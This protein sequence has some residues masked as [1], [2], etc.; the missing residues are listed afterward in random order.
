MTNPNRFPNGFAL[1]PIHIGAKRSSCF[2]EGVMPTM[3]SRCF[4]SVSQGERTVPTSDEFKFSCLGCGQYLLAND[5]R[6]GRHLESRISQN[7]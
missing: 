6:S 5:L 2:H 3:V 7:K 1:H 4:E